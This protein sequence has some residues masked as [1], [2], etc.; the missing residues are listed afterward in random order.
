MMNNIFLKKYNMEALRASFSCFHPLP[1]VGATH[2]PGATYME[3]L[4]AS[5]SCDNPFLLLPKLMSGEL[6]VSE[7]RV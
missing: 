1:P 6:D 7:V 2:Q 5:I 3:A 4:R